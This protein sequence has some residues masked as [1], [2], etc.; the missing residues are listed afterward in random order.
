MKQRPFLKS[1]PPLIFTVC[2]LSGQYSNAKPD[3]DIKSEAI[4]LTTEDYPSQGISLLNEKLANPASTT[5]DWIAY[6]WIKCEAD[7]NQ[8]C[9]GDHLVEAPSGW[10]A[11]KS[12]FTVGHSGRQ[13]SYSVTPVNWYTNDP[14]SPDRFR[15]YN[16]HVMAR[17]SHSLIDR[18][19]TNITLNNV[20]IR[21]IRADATNYDRYA[22]GCEMPRHD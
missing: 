1:L 9:E 21:V 2:L 14:E 15:A 4:K 3:S 12:I 22:A 5:V 20:G 19:G 13:T 11:C 8:H 16:Y 7:W 6:N 17:G 10:Q 18:W